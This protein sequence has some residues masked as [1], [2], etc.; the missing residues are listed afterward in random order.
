MKSTKLN[1]VQK[2]KLAEDIAEEYLRALGYKF[3][4]RN[5]RIGRD[6]I[7][8]VMF[9]PAE[10]VVVF[11]EVKSRTT[12]SS[13]YTPELNLTQSKRAKLFRSAHAWVDLCAY[14]GSYR[15]DVIYIAAG[16][17]TGHIQ[18]ITNT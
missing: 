4:N 17:V 6:E 11:V 16:A 18:E 9:D 14:E 7:D 15:I 1:S 3:Y 12:P 8:L 13:N 10:Q 5:V 2:G